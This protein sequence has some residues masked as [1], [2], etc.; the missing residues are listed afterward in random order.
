MPALGT[1]LL[2]GG[3]Q[4]RH[5]SFGCTHNHTQN[6]DAYG[7]RPHSQIHTELGPGTHEHIDTRP[8]LHVHTQAQRSTYTPRHTH[9]FVYNTHSSRGRPHVG[10]QTYTCRAV[11]ILPKDRHYIYRH[12]YTDLHI[13]GIILSFAQR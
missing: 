5:P 3:K 4:A 7:E 8:N 6:K 10:T 13:Y 1:T 11:H 12:R 9:R 2:P